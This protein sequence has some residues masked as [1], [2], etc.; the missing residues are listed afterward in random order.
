MASD[1]TDKLYDLV[2]KNNVTKEDLVEL[3]QWTQKHKNGSTWERL[4][5]KHAKEV[6]KILIGKYKTGLATTSLFHTY[7]QESMEITNENV[8]DFFKSREKVEEG[9]VKESTQERLDKIPALTA[10]IEALSNIKLNEVSEYKSIIQENE[11]AIT[12]IG[13]EEKLFEFL[14]V[15]NFLNEYRSRVYEE[16]KDIQDSHSELEIK[17]AIMRINSGSL[18]QAVEDFENLSRGKNSL[19]M[20]IDKLFE[21]GERIGDAFEGESKKLDF[22]KSMAIAMVVLYINKERIHFFEI[23]TAFEKLGVFNSTWQKDVSNKLS[24]IDVKLAN[25]EQ[26]LNSLDEQ[27]STLINNTDEIVGALKSG[28]DGVNTRLDSSNLLMGIT[29]YQTYRINKNTNS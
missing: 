25:I 20:N 24:S 6:N 11:E 21:I 10:Q 3:S 13:G 23:Y 15:G 28:F 26:G 29:A 4:S 8:D 22:Y 16:L 19:S 12:E 7:L 9:V 27:F 2:I 1:K 18:D 17:N 14:K 5:N